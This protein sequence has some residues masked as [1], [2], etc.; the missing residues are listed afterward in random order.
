MSKKSREAINSNLKKVLDP[1]RPKRASHLDGL[2]NEY[3]PPEK[4]SVVQ[5]IPPSPREPPSRDEPGSQIAPDPLHNET[6]ARREPPAQ[7]EPAARVLTPR[8]A[9][10]RFPYEVLDATFGK[11][12]PLPRVVLL[13]LYRLAAGFDSNTCHVS[14]GK[15]VSHCKIGE[16]KLR[17]C[18]RELERDGYIRR[19]SIDI[20]HKNPDARGITFEVLLPR[21]PPARREGGAS[22]E[23]GSRDEGGSRNEPNKVNTYKE[24]THKQEQPLAGVRVGS[25]FSLEEC[26][27]YAAHLKQT[28]QGITNP[29]GY[30]TK[31]YRSGETDALIEKFINPTPTLDISKCPDCEGKGYYFPDPSK[32]ETVR[33][34]H[35]R[36]QA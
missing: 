27:R 16:T 3:A 31:I 18:L 23:P 4:K 30:A 1:P 14:I 9:H 15:L 17:A 20:A 6:G 24:N 2:L 32:P 22:R 13:R 36:L 8:A 25:K 12:N 5:D 7:D 21:L 11:V 26:Q 34:K 35:Q 19:V 28:G 33:C 10:F 29:G